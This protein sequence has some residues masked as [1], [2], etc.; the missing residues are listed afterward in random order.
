MPDDLASHAA[1][2]RGF[3]N[4]FVHRDHRPRLLFGLGRKT[5]PRRGLDYRARFLGRFNH[6]ALK[7]LDERFVHAVPPPNSDPAN[8]LPLLRAG[9]FQETTPHSPPF[10]SH[11]PSRQ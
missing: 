10:P 8:I 5:A 7:Y 3:V 9:G 2:E 11:E 1:H 6:Q 4:S